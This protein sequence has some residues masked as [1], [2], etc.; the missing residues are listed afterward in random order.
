MK[1]G[2]AARPAKIKPARNRGLLDEEKL[3]QTTCNFF[4]ARSVAGLAVPTFAIREDPTQRFEP[5]VA[6]VAL[7]LGRRESSGSD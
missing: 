4:R 6:R 1:S 5:F 7:A 2:M 3:A